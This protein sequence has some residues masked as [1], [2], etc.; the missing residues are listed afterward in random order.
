M[1]AACATS[2]S[3]NS[4]V[5]QEN[6][7]EK[8]ILRRR[9]SISFVRGSEHSH[10][11]PFSFCRQ[12]VTSHLLPFC[13]NI[14]CILTFSLHTIAMCCL[15]HHMLFFSCRH[16]LVESLFTPRHV[17]SCLSH[18]RAHSLEYHQAKLLRAMY[19]SHTWARCSTQRQTLWQRRHVSSTFSRFICRI[20]QR[21]AHTFL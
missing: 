6:R 10:A 19:F 15:L 8:Q 18:Q 17:L 1:S 3:H 13:N 5:G 14:S 21:R 20:K 9:K 12:H 7:Q 2:S 11:M 16:A 4:P